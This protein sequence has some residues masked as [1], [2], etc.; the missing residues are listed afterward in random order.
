M[1]KA[2]IYAA[3]R[4]TR[5]GPEFARRP[6]ILIEFGGKSLLEWH[7][8]RLSESGVRELSVITGHER[9]QI[10]ATLPHLEKAHGIKIEEIINPDFTEGSVLSFNVSLPVVLSAGDS[11]LLM[12]GDVLYPTEMLRRLIHSAHPTT[13]LIDRNYST[14][15]DDPVL[16]PLRGGRPFDFIKRWQGEAEQVG[17]SIGFFKADRAD[18]QQIAEETRRRSVG[19]GRLDSYDDVLRVLVQ[20]GK[21]ACEDVTGLPWT[22]VDFPKDVA[23]ARDEVL[24]ALLR[25]TPT[26]AGATR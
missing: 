22:E 5:L 26:G 8:I 25:H 16:V 9:E 20:E 24:P 19:E 3:G 18:L 15:D 14:A 7:A 11:V 17:E 13:M 4:A 1:M 2:F 21:F 12:D 10:A 23:Y 6:K